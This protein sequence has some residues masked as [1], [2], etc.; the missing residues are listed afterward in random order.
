LVVVKA[1]GRVLGKSFSSNMAPDLKVV[2]STNHLVFVHGGGVEVT[3]MADKLGKMQKFI[4][5]PGGFRSRYTDKET[6]E[7]YTMVMAG[8][9]NKEIVLNLQRHGVP[10]VGLSGLDGALVQARRKKKLVILDERGRKRAIDGGYTGTIL[11]VNASLLR[12]LLDEG[13]MPVVSPVA[14]SE[15]FE[16]LNVDG[17]RTAAQV[18]G[19][20]K[21]DRLILLTDVEGLLLEGKIVSKL[22]VVEAK[23]I[24]GQIGGGM[25][26]KVYAAMEALPLSVREVVIASGFAENPISAALE[27]SRGTVISYE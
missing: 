24:L 27:H 20:L 10:A 5:S 6:I 9:L 13:Y 23:E 16:P 22:T 8:K 15:E 25:I 17:D 1:G 11:K 26:T 2:A 21:A 4:T 19:F 12:L 7:I 18:S 3:K 14:L